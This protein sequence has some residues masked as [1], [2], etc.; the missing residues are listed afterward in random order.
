MQAFS[1]FQQ[2]TCASYATVLWMAQHENQRHLISVA[3]MG[4]PSLT[5]P[6]WPASLAKRITVI[7][8]TLTELGESRYV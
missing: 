4:C 8:W 3:S 7:V 6:K 1:R 2:S 5:L